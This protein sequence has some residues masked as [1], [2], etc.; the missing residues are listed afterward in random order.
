MSVS[1][2][3]G[4]LAFIIHGSFNEMSDREAHAAGYSALVRQL[5]T[6]A[7]GDWFGAWLDNKDSANDLTGVVEP[8]VMFA[9]K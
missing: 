6:K 8:R 1:F 5:Y 4:D 2:A 9:K 7:Y 3:R